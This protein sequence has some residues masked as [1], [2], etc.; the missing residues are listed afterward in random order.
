MSLTL[1]LLLGILLGMRHSFEP[2]H[3]AAVSTLLDGRG[4]RSTAILGAFWGIGHSI[5]LLVVGG[6]LAA[7]HGSLP[8]SLGDGFEILVASMLVI[9]GARAVARA[10]PADRG[11]SAAGHFHDAA[12]PHAGNDHVHVGPWTF[13]W[14]P[15]VVGLVHGLAGSGALTA[16]VMADLPTWGTRVAYMAIFGVGSVIGMAGLTGVVGWQLARIERRARL[17]RALA[18]VTGTFSVGL[19]GWW[20]WTAVSSLMRG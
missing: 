16:L 12:E 6:A 20:G 11:T 15:L 3:V 1:G 9:L 4:R 19:G 10:R 2:D 18:L 8:R 14:R 7:L 13:A 5:A 17:S